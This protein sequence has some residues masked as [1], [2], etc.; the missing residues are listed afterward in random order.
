[1]WKNYSGYTITEI[2]IAFSIWCLLSL[3]LVPV[4]TA[5]L[6]QQKEAAASVLAYQL[7]KEELERFV[8]EKKKTNGQVER[9]GMMFELVWGKEGQFA[10]LCVLSDENAEQKVCGYIYEQ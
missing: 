9:Q 3:T 4:S 6:K 8:F 5:L 10:E 7:L 1:V 2:L